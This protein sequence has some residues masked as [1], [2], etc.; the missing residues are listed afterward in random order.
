MRAV[1]QALAPVRLWWAALP[2]RDRQLGALAGVVLG[3]FITW[4]LAVQPAWRT[5]QSAPAQREALDVQWQAMQQLATEAKDF[6]S[7]P[8]VTITS[9]FSLA[10]RMLATFM[11]LVTTVMLRWRTNSRATASVVV[12]RF[13]IRLELSGIAAAQARAM[14]VLAASF[15][16]RRAS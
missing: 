6:R 13:R 12:P 5:L 14:A 10:T 15:M 16:R 3:L 9:Q 11:L 8:P 2:A 1:L 7:A 4:T